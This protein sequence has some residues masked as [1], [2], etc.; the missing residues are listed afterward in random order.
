MKEI[1]QWLG[2]IEAR[3]AKA[4]P[5]PWAY[6]EAETEQWVEADDGLVVYREYYTK[7]DPAV[8]KQTKRDFEFIALVREDVERLCQVVR[9]LIERLENWKE[10]ENG[11]YLCTE[12]AERRS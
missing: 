9:Q 10:T 6:G 11:K 8:Y 2:E 4:T 5:G 3:A 7:P 12:E 1:L